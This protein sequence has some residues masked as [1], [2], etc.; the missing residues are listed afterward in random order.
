MYKTLLPTARFSA[1][2]AVIVCVALVIFAAMQWYFYQETLFFSNQLQHVPWAVDVQTHGKQYRVK[3]GTV[4]TD[5]TVVDGWRER[6]ALR[7]AY[8]K[9]RAQLFPLLAL[10]GVDL[11]QLDR[12][13]L[14]LS[15]IQ[16]A[17]AKRAPKTDAPYIRTGLYPIDSL[18][19]ASKTERA[20]RQFI[21]TGS[22]YDK[23]A[24]TN[25]LHRFAR[26]YATDMQEFF[27]GFRNTVP[28]EAPR[29]GTATS[30]VTYDAMYTALEEILVHARREH[31]EV[32]KHNWCTN[33]VF[34][35]CADHAMRDALRTASTTV[36]N[37]EP[38]TTTTTPIAGSANSVYA[39]AN[40]E[41]LETPLVQIPNSVCI[42]EEH[43]G[44]LFGF[45]APDFDPPRLLSMQ[46]IRLLPIASNTNSPLLS[47]FR[48]A[49]IEYMWAR[50]LTHYD[51][52]LLHID[53]GRAFAVRDIA[54]FSKAHQNMLPTAAVLAIDEN[55]VHAKD[56]QVYILKL[57]HTPNLPDSIRREALDLY[58]SFKNKTAGFAWLVGEIAQIELSHLKLAILY[59]VEF[60]FSAQ[61]MFYARS[62]IF[63]L[64]TSLMNGADRY[65]N[66]FSA[67]P[68]ETPTPFTYLSELPSENQARIAKD[69]A[70][71]LELQNK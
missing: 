46:N 43:P 7:L 54:S 52:P 65:I 38:D 16:Y 27:A 25:E 2:G 57:L 30:I 12:N 40:I 62:G 31:T 48:S 29:Y 20:R 36:T 19:A 69:L 18:A 1:Y 4:Y 71:F 39:A 22:V 50:E 56:A 66:T 53:V 55:V 14:R 51:C 63:A 45:T 34:I 47:F 9:A 61:N 37:I 17:I 41:L 26:I 42:N 32:L 68:P 6:S 44:Y 60:D 49:G 33:G 70:R 67:L 11:D 23:K 58:V 10:A 8:A 5:G 24:Y 35:A 28:T 15:M 13:I 64:G 59:D 21:E 3:N